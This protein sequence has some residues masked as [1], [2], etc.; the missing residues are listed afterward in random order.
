[1]PRSLSLDAE[2][3]GDPERG[4]LALEV[5]GDEVEVDEGTETGADASFFEES[6][7]GDDVDDVPSSVFDLSPLAS[8]I[9]PLSM[10]KLLV[11]FLPEGL[12]S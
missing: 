2:L 11:N 3:L 7:E 1:M 5:D 9:L 8:L 10:L 4:D 12:A 6:A